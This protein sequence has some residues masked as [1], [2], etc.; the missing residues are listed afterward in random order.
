MKKV[1]VVN[2]GKNVKWKF[3]D[4][5]DVDMDEQEGRYTRIVILKNAYLSDV[6][7]FVKGDVPIVADIT[8]FDTDNGF[9]VPFCSNVTISRNDE[10]FKTSFS[11]YQIGD[12]G[13]IEG[14]PVGQ[15]L[16]ICQSIAMNREYLS[17]DTPINYDEGIDFIASVHENFELNIG[18]FYAKCAVV[19]NNL[20]TEA[21]NY[22]IRIDDLIKGSEFILDFD[23]QMKVPMTQF[24]NY[25]KI[26]VKR[27]K[28]IEIDYTINNTETGIKIN[29]KENKNSTIQ[30]IKSWMIEYVSNIDKREME[31]NLTNISKR[32][33]IDIL[34]LELQVQVDSFKNSV[35]ILKVENKYLKDNNQFL[36]GL[37]TNLSTQ[38]TIIVNQ[39]QINSFLDSGT[40][41]LGSSN[42]TDRELLRIIYENTNSNE[43][44]QELINHLKTIRDADEDATVIKEAKESF[45]KKMGKEL[46][47]ETSKEFIKKAIGFGFE[48][49]V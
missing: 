28:E 34:K 13:E 8:F 17:V 42:D 33:N 44:R 22:L 40:R 1:R 39:T 35:E 27:S 23:E 21:V 20:I 41:Q 7:E 18:I 36:Q 48:N 5:V 3:D 38:N 26:Y 10:E 14:Y 47:S 25:F 9:G 32:K 46:L 15:V 19:F 43:E 6:S 2:N 49:F 29:F 12:T 16:R 30:E 31:T 24:L 45:W 4:R 37:L 11:F